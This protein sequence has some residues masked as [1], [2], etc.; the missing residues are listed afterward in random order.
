MDYKIVN[1]VFN[2]MIQNTIITTNLNNIE[3][4]IDTTFDVSNMKSFSLI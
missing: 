2:L 3:I 4:V 1:T